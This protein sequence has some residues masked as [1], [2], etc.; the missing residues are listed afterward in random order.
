MKS[1]I[2]FSGSSPIL[3]LTTFESFSHAK[4][5]EKLAQKGIKKFIAFKVPIELCEKKYGEHFEAVMRDVTQSDDLQI[6]DIDGHRVFHNFSF[7]EMGVET[8]LVSFFM[9]AYHLEGAKVT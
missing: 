6:L 7:K 1:G 2:I 4:F 8:T 9:T 3:V 5:V